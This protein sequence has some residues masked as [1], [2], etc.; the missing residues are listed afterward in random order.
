MLP[1]RTPPDIPRNQSEMRLFE[2]C[3]H[4]LDL[5]MWLSFRYPDYFTQQEQ[6]QMERDL[7]AELITAGLE[8]M[9]SGD[10]E[11]MSTLARSCESGGKRNDSLSNSTLEPWNSRL[12]KDKRVRNARFEKYAQRFLSNSSHN[13]NRD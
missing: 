2:L 5:Y 6:A 8:I 10:V 9:T 13:L 12:I 3:H 11:E 1:I 4:V 7:C